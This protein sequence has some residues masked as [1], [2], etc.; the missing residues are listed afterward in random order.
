MNA[1]NLIDYVIARE[2]TLPPLRAGLYEYVLAG[3]GLF[4]RSERDGLQAT[5]PV[6]QCTMR[7]L[8]PID[9]CIELTLPRMPADLTRE[10]L[11]QARRERDADGQ[12]LE[13]MYHLTWDHAARRWQ[14]VK[15]AQR[16]MVGAVHPVGPFMGTSYETYLIEVH[17]HH[18]LTF[19]EFSPTDD[20][21]EAGMF[22]LFGLLVDIFAKPRLRLRVS[23]FGYHW[24]IPASSV[25][26]LPPELSEIVFRRQEA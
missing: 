26:D 2:A 15:P 3:N 18:G 22:R 25:F 11:D 1:L 9:P 5:I 10:M 19:H 12:A 14:M 6:A 21:S 4:V 17:S 24:E 16:Q 7:G 13:V 23:V 8:S 20:A